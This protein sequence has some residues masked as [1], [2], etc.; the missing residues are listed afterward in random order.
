MALLAHNQWLENILA[1]TSGTSHAQKVIDNKPADLKDA[2]W[3]AAGTKYEEPVTL[4]PAATCNQLFPVHENVRIAAGGPIA[5]DV[6]KCQLE[7]LDF[8]SYSVQ[9]TDAERARLAAIFPNGVCDWTQPSV[10]RLDLMD[11]WLSYPSA[12][13]PVPLED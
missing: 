8:G 9:F 3:D 7:P 12:G 1:D 4:D 5:A 13:N 11:T 6:L 10:N 2:C